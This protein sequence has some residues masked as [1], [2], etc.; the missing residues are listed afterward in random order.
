MYTK[1]SRMGYKEAQVGEV[2]VQV[3]NKNLHG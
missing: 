2:Q 3:Q 1:I